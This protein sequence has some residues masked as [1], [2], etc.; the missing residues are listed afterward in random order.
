M[1]FIVVVSFNIVNGIAIIAETD[2]RINE[3]TVL[4][5][6]AEVADNWDGLHKRRR[7]AS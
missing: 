2:V 5:Q 3:L 1:S 4:E 7:A 6:I